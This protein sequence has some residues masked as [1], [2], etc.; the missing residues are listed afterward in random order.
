MSLVMLTGIVASLVG[1]LWAKYEHDNPNYWVAWGLSQTGAN[2]INVATTLLFPGAYLLILFAPGH[3]W[4]FA[5]GMVL[6]THFIGVQIFCGLLYGTIA[7]LLARR[8]IERRIER[9][10]R[11]RGEGEDGGE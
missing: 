10:T 11:T 7:V 9:A 5:I 3:G 1:A 2:V 8:R 6:A 4:L